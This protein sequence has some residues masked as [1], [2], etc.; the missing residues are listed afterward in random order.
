MTIVLKGENIAGK[1]ETSKI[2]NELNQLVDN[3]DSYTS[4]NTGNVNYNITAS[5]LLY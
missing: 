4:I 5:I 3:K 1:Q 2:K